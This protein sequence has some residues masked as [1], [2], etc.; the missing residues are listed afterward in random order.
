MLQKEGDKESEVARGEGERRENK[1][2]ER[3]S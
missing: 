3:E 1:R 2:G